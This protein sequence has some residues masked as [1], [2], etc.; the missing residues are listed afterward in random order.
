MAAISAGKTMIKKF[1]DRFI[2]KKADLQ[3]A[4]SASHPED[5]QAVV[6]AVVSV[7]NNP[8]DYE[9]IDPERIHKIDD[10]DYQG[11]LV[12]G[13][14]CTGYQPTSYWYVK[15]SY[16]SCGACDTLEAIRGYG[17]DKPTAEQVRNYMTLALHIVQGLKKMG[18]DDSI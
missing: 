11:T 17:D 10:G 14:A 5:Y 2:E 8:D 1:I 13:I 18:D 9:S 12:F 15:V 16:G 4:F 3:A 6:K 7:L